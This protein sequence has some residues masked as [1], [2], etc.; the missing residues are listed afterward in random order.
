MNEINLAIEEAKIGIR[1]H[2]GGPFGAVIIND[3]GEVISCA[4]NE[5]LKTKDPTA[6][7]EIVA[8]RKA[9]QQ[10]NTANLSGH[11]IYS[12]CEPCPMCLSAI[13]WANIETV[14][15]GSSRLDASQKG[16]KDKKIYDYLDNKN[17]ILKREKIESK[18]CQELMTSYDGKIY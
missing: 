18:E 9:C 8:I 5:V 2:D 10:L 16:F 15:Y 7:A 3:E 4:H 14:Y 11:T 12:T 17:S 6:H 1:N 13:I